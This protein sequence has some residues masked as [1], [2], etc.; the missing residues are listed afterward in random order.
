MGLALALTMPWAA[1]AAGEIEVSPDGSSWGS[2]LPQPLFSDLALVPRGS[3]NAQF[4][5][6]NSSGDDAF[7]RIV[8]QDVNYSSPVLGDAL[9]L[10]LA[11]GGASGEPARLSSATPCRVLFEGTLPVGASRPLLT[12]LS[13]GDLSGT[14]GQSETATFSIGIQLSGSSLGTLP[15]T[16]CGSPGVVIEVTPFDSR[17]ATIATVGVEPNTWQLFEELLVLLLVAALVA[18]AGAQWAVATWI[19]RRRELDEHERQYLEDLA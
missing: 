1:A 11:V 9:T 7:L 19:R 12:S 3:A 2:Q 13:L 6:R 15:A 4:L 10:A 17:V 14:Q 16:D 8:V 5:L 18:G